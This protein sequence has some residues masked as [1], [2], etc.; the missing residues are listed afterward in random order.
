MSIDVTI[1][2]K[3]LMKKELPLKV[4]LGNNL[5]YGTF[6]GLRLVPGVI[7]GNEFIAYNSDRIGRG[8]SVTYDPAKKQEITL[9]ALT[10][11]STEELHEFYQCVGRIVNHWKCELEVDGEKITPD[12]FQRGLPQMCR[13]NEGALRNFSDDILNGEKGNLTL[14]CAF[15]P[16][17]IGKD[18]AE[19]FEKDGVGAFRDWL[20]KKQ[21][22]DAYYAKPGFFDENGTVIGRYVLTENTLSIF[23]LK[24]HVPFGSIDKRTNKPLVCDGYKMYLYS[25]TK[26]SILGIL[27]YEE[28]FQYI[29]SKKI[30]RYDAEH[31]VVKP[32]YLAELNGI[33]AAAHEAET[34]IGG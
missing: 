15:W 28:F 26:D 9:R 10:P 33:L 29:N 19:L 21:S 12:A 5:S 2:Q 32:L 23:P 20:H 24:G 22:M 18:E 17:V 16:L 6:D 11:T 13:F 14:F 27:P 31:V 34:E 25:T 8:F 30:S 4:I 3:S 7:N 1:R